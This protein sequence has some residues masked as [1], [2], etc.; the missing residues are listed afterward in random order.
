ML[1]DLSEAFFFYLRSIHGVICVLCAGPARPQPFSRI[2]CYLSSALLLPDLAEQLPLSVQPQLRPTRSH[3]TVSA[4]PVPSLDG[5]GL[6]PAKWDPHG[7]HQSGP[8]Q[9][10]PHAHPPEDREGQAERAPRGIS[11]HNTG[12]GTENGTGAHPGE[13]PS[14]SQ[15]SGLSAPR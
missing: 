11:Q 4:R 5:A 6:G 15:H 9:E 1:Y 7:S 13:Q 2:P 10:L 12:N 3:G 14:I 8:C